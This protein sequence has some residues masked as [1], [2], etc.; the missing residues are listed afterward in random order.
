VNSDELIDLYALRQAGEVSEREVVAWGERRVTDDDLVLPIALL[1][2]TAHRHDVDVA[3]EEV[4]AA[5]ALA[6]PRASE[7]ALIA[8]MARCRQILDGAVTP[9]EGAR[10]LA[11]IGRRFPE[12][13]KSVAVF[14][15]ILDDLD[16]GFVTE[17]DARAQVVDHVGRLIA[18]ASS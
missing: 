17:E 3:I 13:L 9:V 11:S 7:V 5:M 12:V 2:E 15:G 16:E 14:I 6:L 1:P 4:A 8:V 18:Q 10:S